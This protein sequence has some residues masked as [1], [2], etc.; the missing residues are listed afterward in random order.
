MQFLVFWCTSH[1]CEEGAWSR[2]TGPFIHRLLG[3]FGSYHKPPP[4][5]L[6][7]NP[8]WGSIIGEGRPLPGR[9][10]KSE[11]TIG[12]AE[13]VDRCLG[14]LE[15]LVSTS[16]LRR[17]VD[18]CLGDLKELRRPPPGRLKKREHPGWARCHGRPPPGRPSRTE[19]INDDEHLGGVSC[20]GFSGSRFINHDLPKQE[21]DQIICLVLW[22]SKNYVLVVFK[23]ELGA[24]RVS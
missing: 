6:R 18:R 21:Q 19:D 22:Y 2:F 15:E 9:L 7:N 1:S 23:I 20:Q 3:I 4:G 14:G 16:C 17:R 8:L 13:T 11:R 24:G 10:R 12:V 5:R